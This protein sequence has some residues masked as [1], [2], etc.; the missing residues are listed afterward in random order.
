[1]KKIINQI[2][3]ELNCHHL[4][5]GIGPSFCATANRKSTVQNSGILTYNLLASAG[6]WNPNL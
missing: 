2:I 5:F 3:Q 6:K 1:M 4:H